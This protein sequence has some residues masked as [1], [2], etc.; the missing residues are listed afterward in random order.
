[1]TCD[2]V[3]DRLPEH[4]L[5]TLDETEDL[6]IRRHLR[7]CA[8]CRREFA[9]IGE[10]LTM[11]AARRPRPDA[12]R[13][14]CATACSACSRR[15][16]ARTPSWCPTP[17]GRARERGSCA[18]A[19]SSRSSLVAVWGLSVA[20]TRERAL[21]DA[22]SYRRLL[23]HPRRRGV[24]GRGRCER[25]RLGPHRRAASCCTTPRS[26]SRGE[27]CSCGRRSSPGSVARDPL[28]RRR[29]ARSICTRRSSTD[30]RRRD[31]ARHAPTTS[32][33]FDRLTITGARRH[34]RS[35]PRD[36]HARPSASTTSRFTAR[37]TAPNRYLYW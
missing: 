3:R 25:S 34:R 31:L 16:G 22:Q 35:P 17:R 2:E 14:S 21:E 10:G 12:A 6:R 24:P 33:P 36:D 32:T 5:G 18:A 20:A 7:G 37:G 13:R 19:A 15:S 26:S 23:E 11:F 8:Q 9:A 29:R 28:G 27:S 1:M 30:G 4:A